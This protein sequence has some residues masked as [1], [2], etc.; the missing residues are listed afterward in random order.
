MPARF[1]LKQITLGKPASEVTSIALRILPR[2]SAWF[3]MRLSPLP[4]PWVGV[5]VQISPYFFSMGH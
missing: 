2:H 5:M 4:M 1:P 3:S